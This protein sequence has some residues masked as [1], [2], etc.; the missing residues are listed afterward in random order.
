MA[1][2]EIII[3]LIG[4]TG[5]GKTSFAKYAGC[6]VVDRSR[7]TECRDYHTNVKGRDFWIIDTPGL[8]DLP[9]GN[10]AILK[11]LAQTLN[12][13]GPLKVRGA[14]FF[15]RITDGRFGGSA[16]TH[17]EIFKQICGQSF[18]HQAVFV[19][20]MWNKTGPGRSRYEAISQE[21]ETKYFRLTPEYTKVL[22]FEND[23]S[24][25]QKVLEFL[26]GAPAKGQLLLGDEVKRVGSSLS[27]VRKTSA[28]KAITKASG[29]GGCVIL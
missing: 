21:L 13:L 18:S 17:L 20:T 4:P 1:G 15:H 23:E 5:S 8:D 14:I 16:R 25:A 29:S 6:K 24:S 7:T 28:G 12:K 11:D 3:L 26:A 22:Q 27:G 10:L 19:T 9:A 2:G